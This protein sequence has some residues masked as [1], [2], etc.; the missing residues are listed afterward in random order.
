MTVKKAIAQGLVGLYEL[1]WGV[2]SMLLMYWR[3]SLWSILW[4]FPLLVVLRVTIEALWTF[5]RTIFDDI[6]NAGPP[7]RA[8]GLPYTSMQVDVTDGD[9]FDH[10]LRL[11]WGQTYDPEFGYVAKPAVVYVKRLTS[12][13]VTLGFVPWPHLY[14]AKWHVAKG[15]KP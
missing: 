4:I 14:T 7:L 12:S 2:G 5:G 1:S 9:E 15:L 6:Y 11:N 3:D 8:T 10:M 13:M